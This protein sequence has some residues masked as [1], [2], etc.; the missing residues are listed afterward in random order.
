MP[1]VQSKHR[2]GPLKQQNKPHKHGSHKSR[3]SLSKIN[4]G[5]YL[6]L[7]MEQCSSCVCVCVCVSIVVCWNEGPRAQEGGG[8]MGWPTPPT[9]GYMCDTSDSDRITHIPNITDKIF[10]LAPSSIVLYL[11][12][13]LTLW[14]TALWLTVAQPRD[15]FVK[16]SLDCCDMNKS[17]CRWTTWLHKD[18]GNWIPNRNQQLDEAAVVVLPYMQILHC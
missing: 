4:K 9:Q 7:M 16:L 8:T 2:P 18:N 15:T 13:Y 17:K 12:T 6:L 5:L 14:V 1:I 3:A 11:G 10:P